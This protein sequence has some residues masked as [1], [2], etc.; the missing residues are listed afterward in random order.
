MMQPFE[1]TASAV[2][3]ICP[4]IETWETGNRWLEEERERGRIAKV[5]EQQ[6]GEGGEKM[7]KRPEGRSHV[8]SPRTGRVESEGE[9]EEGSPAHFPLV[10]HDGADHQQR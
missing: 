3:E 5:C 8:T 6:M 1:V 2:S 10:P 4:A 9:E 7:V